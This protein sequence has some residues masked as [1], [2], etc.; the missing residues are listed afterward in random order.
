MITSLMRSTRTGTRPRQNSRCRPGAQKR[1]PTEG[2]GGLAGALPNSRHSPCGPRTQISPFSPGPRRRRLIPAVR[3][4]RSWFPAERFPRILA[5]TRRTDYRS[6]P[7]RPPQPIAFDQTHPV[8]CL[9]RARTSTGSG[10]PPEMQCGWRQIGAAL[11]RRRI[12]GHCK[13]VGTP[14]NRVGRLPWRPHFIT[15]PCRTAATR[16]LGAQTRCPDSSP[17]SSGEN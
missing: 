12:D 2:Q 15:L 1:R 7:A 11:L 9:E 16:Q 5:L 3:G 13:R 17:R 4:S 10:A 8:N 6:R 14:G